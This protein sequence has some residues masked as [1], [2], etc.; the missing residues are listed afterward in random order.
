MEGFPGGATDLSH[1]Q[2]TMEAVEHACSSIQ[3]S[4]LFDHC[5]KLMLSL[6]HVSSDFRVLWLMFSCMVV[7]LVLASSMFQFIW[8]SYSLFIS[9]PKITLLVSLFIFWSNIPTQGNFCESWIG[10]RLRSKESGSSQQSGSLAGGL[11]SYEALPGSG[12]YSSSRVYPRCIISASTC[13]ISLLKWLEIKMQG[14]ICCQA[15]R[16]TKYVWIGGVG[17]AL[18]SKTPWDCNTPPLSTTICLISHSVPT[19]TLVIPTLSPRNLSLLAS[20]SSFLK[21]AKNSF[22]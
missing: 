13:Q 17:E 9:F 20:F 21:E 6:F 7:D 2:S 10:T 12:Y 4:S 15:W 14:W 18:I 8:V 22:Y 16:P 19:L 1:L 5:L 11:V 3:V